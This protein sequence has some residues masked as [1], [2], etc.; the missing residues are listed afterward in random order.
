[1]IADE[2]NPKDPVVK[3]FVK[4]SIS[5]MFTKFRKGEKSKL[6]Q[7][8]I[9]VIEICIRFYPK[10]VSKQENL[11]FCVIFA[12]MLT[13]SQNFEKVSEDFIMPL[14]IELGVEDAII[15]EILTIKGNKIF[16]DENN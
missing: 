9:G 14:A 10:D 3:E 11:A 7:S 2:F 8:E 1:M 6:H 5:D 13:D 15:H 12:T 4:Q 16:G